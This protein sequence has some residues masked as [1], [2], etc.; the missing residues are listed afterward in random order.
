M[1]LEGDHH[2]CVAV[3]HDGEKLP[4]HIVPFELIKGAAR[5]YAFGTKKY[6]RFNFRNKPGLEYSRTA[7]AVV[8]H[9]LEW[10]HEMENDPESGLSHL[11]HAAASLGML[12]DTVARVRAGYLPADRDDRWKEPQ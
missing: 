7:R 4:L 10:L 6:A 1:M 5:A 2:F 11:D 8:N 9:V 3:K 12:M